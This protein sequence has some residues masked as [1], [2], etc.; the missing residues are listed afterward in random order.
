MVTEREK[1]IRGE[2]FQSSKRGLVKAPCRVSDNY[3][4][5]ILTI[6]FLISI[7]NICTLLYLT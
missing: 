3:G 2:P 6:L 4:R 1:M 7:E 5:E